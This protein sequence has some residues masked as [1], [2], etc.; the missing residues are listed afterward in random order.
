MNCTLHLYQSRSAPEIER[1]L[2]E[3]HDRLAA[4]SA[5]VAY[6]LDGELAPGVAAEGA[7]RLAQL[8][9]RWLDEVRDPGP[10]AA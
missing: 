10:D 2:A 5:L 6:A 8:A 4:A 3:A 9:D 1:G 7:H